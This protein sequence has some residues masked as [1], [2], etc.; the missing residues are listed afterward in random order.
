MIKIQLN[1]IGI[2]GESKQDSFEDLCMHICCRKLKITS[3][4]SYKNQPGI[5]TEPFDVKGVKYG[6]QVKYFE[7]RFDW[8][9]I[10]HSILGKKNSKTK[11][12]NIKLIYPENVFKKYSLKKLYIY[13]NK[14]KTLHGRNKTKIEVL[15]TDLASLYKA[16]IE[17]IC[18]KPLSFE[19]SKPEN[20]DLAHLYFGVSD[21][22]GFVKNSLDTEK[23]T[24]FNSKQYICLPFHDRKGTLINTLDKVLL[25][26]SSPVTLIAG[27][28][29]S[30]KSIFIQKLLITLGGLDKSTE[31]GM[32]KVINDQKAVP[33]LVNLKDCVFESLESIIRSRASDYKL[34]GK[35][36]K[37]T[38]LFDG[39]DEVDE[40]KCD[41]ILSF[42]FSLSRK[43][44]TKQ[45]IVTCRKGNINKI[46]LYSYFKTIDEYLISDLP[47]QYLLKYFQ[48]KGSKNKL[49]K[50]RKLTKSNPNL[51]IEIKDIL[52]VELLWQ[53]IEEVNEGT[54]V[55]DLLGQK[56][57]YLLDSSEHQNNLMKLNVLEPK[58]AK[59]LDI[60]QDISFEFQDQRKGMFQFRFTL[61]DLQKIILNKYQRLDYNSTNRIINY[62]AD[63]F[64]D[65]SSITGSNSYM[66][67][68]RRYQEYFFTKRLK[69]EYELN[70]LI[71]RELNLLSNREYFENIFLKYLRREYE[72]SKNLI[73]L[74]EL[75]LIDVYL[76]KH[77]GFGVDEAHY[78]NSSEFIPALLAQDIE[79]YN[80][81]M[82]DESLHVAEKVGINTSDVD[83]KF[84]S[85][86]KN[87]KCYQSEDF[88]RSIY[89]EGISK[90][91]SSTVL[92][93]KAGKQELALNNLS[94]LDYL[95]KQYKKYQ[96][97]EKID[98]DMTDPYWTCIEDWVYILAEI[99]K[100]D[101]ISVLE[102]I[103]KNYEEDSNSNYISHKATS[104][105]RLF[106]AFLN[107]CLIRNVTELIDLIDSFSSFEKYETVGVLIKLENLP[108]LF[109]NVQLNLRVKSIVMKLTDE[110]DTNN[111]FLLFYKK[112]FDIELT[113]ENCQLAY[114]KLKEIRNERPMDWR[115]SDSH[116][117]YA[118]LA[119]VLGE[120]TFDKY[121]S[122][123]GGHH[124]R[125]YN[126]LVVFSAIFDGYLN[127][128][129]GNTSLDNVGQ[130]YI[131][132]VSTHDELREGNEHL[133]WDVAA[134]WAVMFSFS[135]DPEGTKEL[136]IEKI[137]DKDNYFKDFK[138]YS[139][140]HKL[141]P[142]LYGSLVKEGDI[143]KF[144]VELNDWED[145]YQS[146]VDRCF[147]LSKLYVKTN[148]YKAKLYFQKGI[149]DGI[150]RHG[151]RKDTIVS[152]SLVEALEN[153]WSN[154]YTTQEDLIEYSNKV[155]E[156]TLRVSQITDGKGTWR[157]PYNLIDT[158]A[159]FDIKLAES[160]KNRLIDANG[161]RNTSNSALESV[162]L[163]K[164]KRGYP[165]EEILSEISKLR[166]DYDYKG[167]VNTQHY[168][169]KFSIY[170][171]LADSYLYSSEENRTSFDKA[172]EITEIIKEENI[173]NFL[174][175]KFDN[176]IKLKFQKLCDKYSY[177]FELNLEKAK[178]ESNENEN[179][180]VQK[181]ENTKEKQELEKLFN[182]LN[183][184]EN[185]IT[186]KN[187]NSWN[188]L[189]EKNID[190]FGNINLFIQLLKENNYPH[191]N[192][193][194][195]NSSYFYMG[196]AVSISN[197]E[198]RNEIFEYL[199][200]NTGHGG[201]ANLIETYSVLKDKDMCI[202][203]FN[204]YL[205]FCDLL[206]Y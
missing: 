50:Y 45:I 118:M 18:E 21:E 83:S 2:K 33:M 26:Q 1:S 175:D 75:N 144:E 84:I 159:K 36:I 89:E 202:S 12:K 60:V 200:T 62:I 17:F 15:L 11:S 41:Q 105:Q 130:Q 150:L 5:E 53:M 55:L 117:T 138:F 57:D 151:W 143:S 70:P 121:L 80:E 94:K 102:I 114:S 76:G 180:F 156:L 129:Q 125:Y 185:K 28:P 157:G 148:K 203:L 155:F 181:L 51:L 109:E 198:S 99:K 34:E 82:A 120:I 162:I 81:I 172:C 43:K 96:F 164:I 101:V 133:S 190:L 13:S 93:W 107:V 132:Y 6:F 19:L 137:K 23:V 154:K 161:Y 63:L 27:N 24:F 167:S 186:L 187:F 58:R 67:K 153:L 88:L 205:K 124:F 40:H 140:L 87:T 123:K 32:L 91:I 71:V 47:P 176:E 54:N 68:H 115:F 73:G 195:N 168:E 3:I 112:I 22:L 131:R 38:Y 85:W 184:Y 110:I 199:A 196:L 49:S 10:S 139:E 122:D 183:N 192:W 171:G 14:E 39:L 77:T 135:K 100:L 126:E 74:I 136:L 163:G 25:N 160:F 35:P 108:I 7:N 141:N 44:S 37:Y 146:Y 178:N 182:D 166:Q 179:L 147:G 119:Y 66:F 42:M 31:R 201:F 111:L 4:D 145:D 173:S 48:A 103:R 59:I 90:L 204:S 158:I 46:R 142:N 29:G 170:V 69:Q 113:D 116:Y 134:F 56:I 152:V 65:F 52:L 165:Y 169:Q 206:V 149:N 97:I 191:S 106:R 127:L 194:S 9:Q 30:G 72:I 189:I 193:Y 61:P 86:E 64:F 78:M 95:D 20:L 16:S 98:Q 197:I 8:S 79:V 174:N 128:L 177:S 188:I 104:N 92:F